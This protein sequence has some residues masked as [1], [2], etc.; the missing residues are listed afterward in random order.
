MKLAF[1]LDGV[2]RDINA[3][4]NDKYN[5]PYPKIWFWKH[6]NK[7][8]FAWVKEDYY[9]ALVYAPIT[10]YFLPIYKW[11]NGN[12][13]EVWTCQPEE[14]RKYT[15]LW[16]LNHFGEDYQIHYLNTKEK[17]ERLD[18]HKE[19]YLFEDNPLFSSYERIL[20][21]DRSYN[22]HIKAQYR[23]KNKKDL[24]EWLK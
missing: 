7:D 9:R 11:L 17:R 4:L 21:I 23:I 6:K 5:I 15:R 12:K 16:L 3:Y 10:E 14:W 24:R 2:L 1:D 18:E 8:I 20:L 19:F 22:Q 13:I